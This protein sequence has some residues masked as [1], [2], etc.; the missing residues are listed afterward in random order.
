ME[1]VHLDERRYWKWLD[2]LDRTRRGA[3]MRRIDSLRQYGLEIGM[4]TIRRL[5]GGVWEVR[6]PL[7]ERMYFTVIDG[8]AVFVAYGNKD[9]QLRDTVVAQRRAAEARDAH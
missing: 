4:P 2:K 6:S 8:V 7:G 1:I 5:F 3:V 9:T